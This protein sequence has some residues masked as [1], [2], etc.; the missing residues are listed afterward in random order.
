MGTR[1]SLAVLFFAY[2]LHAST[3]QLSSDLVNENND[4]IGEN[5]LIVP[6]GTWAVGP[7]GANWSSYA[8]AGGGP[9]TVEAPQG[10]PWTIF[11]EIFSLPF[12]GASGS[13][14]IWADD[15][16]SANLDGQTVLTP[17]KL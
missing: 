7:A 4:R 16:V 3:I 10:N 2:A 8:N 9:D 12:P 11:T 17:A 6:L 5:V 14:R 1:L 15:T 13:V